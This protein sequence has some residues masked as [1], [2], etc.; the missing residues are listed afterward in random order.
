LRWVVCSW[1]GVRGEL[2]GRGG[3]CVRWLIRWLDAIVSGGRDVAV[4]GAAHLVVVSGAALLRPDAQVFEAMLEGWG[5]QQV[6][7]QL[8]GRR[9]A[10]ALGRC[11]GS[12]TTTV[13]SRGR[14]CRRIWRS[15]RRTWCRCVVWRTRRCGCYQQ[16]VRLFLGYVCDP[17]YGWD[18]EC[19]SRFGS[20]PVQICHRRGT[21]PR[22]APRRASR[23]WS[24]G[25]HPSRVADVVRRCGRSGRLGAPPGPQGST[26]R[27]IG[28]RRC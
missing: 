14:G 22:I 17:V 18:R 15:G 20:H 23:R 25:V 24:A 6:S 27:P 26:R 7:R 8:S 2:R 3:G 16:T 28:T 19:E 9:S 4:A 5:R 21:R 12:R 11:A 13:S 1:R 10:R